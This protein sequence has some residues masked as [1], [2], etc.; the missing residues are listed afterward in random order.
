MSNIN[1]LRLILCFLVKNARFYF[2]RYTF[3]A[4]KLLE[5]NVELDR[6]YGRMYPE[7]DNKRA[8]VYMPVT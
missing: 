2:A 4:F 8:A 5:T 7:R 3:T 1:K 6:F